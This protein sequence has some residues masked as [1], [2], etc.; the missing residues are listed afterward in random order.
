MKRVFSAITVYRVSVKA[1]S[2]VFRYPASLVIQNSYLLLYCS[3]VSPLCRLTTGRDRTVGKN[4]SR[5][6][7]HFIVWPV[8]VVCRC[9]RVV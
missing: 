9:D 6:A 4:T 1:P 8:V 7:A 2:F 3:C 5:I